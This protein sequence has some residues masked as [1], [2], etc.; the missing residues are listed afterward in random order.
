MSKITIFTLLL[1]LLSCGY[2]P[3]TSTKRNA[4]EYLTYDGASDL[5]R[6]DYYDVLNT[7]KKNNE[8]KTN[9]NIAKLIK[10]PSKP[11]KIPD[12]LISISV[13]EDVPLKDVLLEI[14]R[15]ANLDIQISPKIDASIIITAKN[16][17][18]R[19]VLESITQI[20]NVRY[21]EVD[22]ILIFEE[23]SPYV[24]TYNV[25]FINLIRSNSTS[26]SSSTGLSG[27]GSTSSQSS[28]SSFSLSG[29]AEDNLWE[30][31]NTSIK[32]IVSEDT[33]NEQLNKE[34]AKER[35]AKLQIKNMSNASNSLAPQP[36]VAPS[37]TT[38]PTQLQGQQQQGPLGQNTI[39][40]NKQGGLIAVFAT[41]K[42]HRK[43]DKYLKLLQKK[44]TAQ[45][46]IE[47]KI[48]EVT[49]DNTYKNGIDW[50]GIAGQIGNVALTASTGFASNLAAST[51]TPVK[52]I[53]G[54]Q[55]VT[56]TIEMLNKFGTV[57]TLISPRLNA[58]NNQTAVLSRA[59]NTVYFNMSIT[60]NFVNTGTNAVGTNAQQFTISSIPQTVPIGIDLSILPV[61]NFD[62]R[63]I[64]MN[65]RPSIISQNGF[66][67]DPG[68]AYLAKQSALTSGIS[69]N[70]PITSAKTFDTMVNIKD[71][72]TMIMGGFTSRVDTITES[73]WPFL[74]EIPIIGTLFKE[75]QSTESIVE[76]VLIIKATLIDNGENNI[77]ESDRR[78]YDKMTNYSRKGV[79]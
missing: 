45:V 76:T 32:Q 53:L 14:G 28:S 46:L 25:N 71:G 6:S 34:K 5:S 52:L 77:E 27:N 68:F 2:T 67:A 50:S 31:I 23:D 21:H 57:K 1:S 58:T 62:K 12:K 36:P 66:Q 72:D 64:M 3:N 18:L 78:F 51:L 40:I 38:Q 70:I 8:K 73:G 26:K 63:E 69:N 43:I 15:M 56:A 7:P 17:P 48:L 4:N 79:L 33:L 9:P 65:V 37:A 16:K 75:K 11:D 30:D 55:N 60:N 10:T 61:I 19:D 39:S 74:S 47:V 13:T 42:G 44:M 59:E 41:K 22:G 20:A 24:E 35:D 49:L 29:K 54:S